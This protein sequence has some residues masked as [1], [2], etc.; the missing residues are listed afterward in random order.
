MFSFDGAANLAYTR[1]LLRR[2]AAHEKVEH[3]R[4]ESG[5]SNQ[6]MHVYAPVN[7]YIIQ[8]QCATPASPRLAPLYFAFSK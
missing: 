4:K 2:D 3:E 1:R 8:Q 6:S 5:F 7:D